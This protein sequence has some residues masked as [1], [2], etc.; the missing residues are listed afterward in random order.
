MQRNK[1]WGFPHLSSAVWWFMKLSPF[2][3]VDI[4]QL[5]TLGLRGSKAENKL[6]KK[7]ISSLKGL[8]G[9]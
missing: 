2:S 9:L 8:W 4:S 6:A 5:H 7:N 3:K 1:E